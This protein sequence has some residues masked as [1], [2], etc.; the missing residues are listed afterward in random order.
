MTAVVTG[1][2][3]AGTPP[4]ASAPSPAPV[5][6]GSPRRRR[7][8]P[9]IVLP[10]GVVTLFWL[11]SLV[12]HGYQDPNFTDPG[13]LSP[14]GTGRHGS[15]ELAERLR[16][17]GIT[18]ERVTSSVAA[19]EAAR[20]RDATIL[21]PAPDLL[22]GRIVPELMGAQ[23][24]HR[25]VLVQPSL[26]GRF[27]SGLAV[28]LAHDRWATKTAEPGCADPVAEAA[29]TATVY[30]DRYLGEGLSTY[31]YQGALVG[32]R[33]LDVEV[34]LVG[35]TEPFRND[36]IREVGNE[37]LVTGLLT[38]H[39]LLI[40]VDVHE[41]EIHPQLPGFDPRYERADQDRTNTG[42]PLLDAFPVQ[43][44]TAFL[45][46]VGAGVLLAIALARRLGPPVPEP[47]PVIVPAAEAVT[48]R[49]RL[50]RRIRARGSSLL[51][52]RGAALARLA[53]TID[54]LARSPERDLAAPGPRRD[55]FVQAV[56]GRS[57]WPEAA[58]TSVLFG[59]LPESDPALVTAA[60]DLDRL[61]AAVLAASAGGSS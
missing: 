33:A 34:L 30:R 22:D 16:E 37:K 20:G 59:P 23:G 9:R 54:P 27:G 44:W 43:L 17:Q 4:V 32:G 31:C 13:T 50:Y 49:G 41:S 15:S 48:G 42:D 14:L 55:A 35:A 8:W 19:V 36:R 28:G 51:T 40:W 3:P 52:L 18:I 6:P 39:N 58:V 12:A 61:V 38:Q 7:R 57:G 21:V 56:A 5:S 47:L 60:A 25:V 46:L 10:L 11:V 26:L 45:V 2:P 24:L 53:R 1:A 29:G